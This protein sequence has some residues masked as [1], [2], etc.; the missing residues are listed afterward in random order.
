MTDKRQIKILA[1]VHGYFPNHN[2]GAEAM[3]HQILMDLKHKGHEVKV[4]T[5]D[6]GADNYE[7]IPLTEAGIG[8]DQALAEWADVIFTHLDYTRFAVRLGNRNRKPVVHL[9][10]N[11]RQL[12]YHNILDKST[13]A[14]AIANSEWIKLTIKKNI[15][16]LV[17]FPPTIPERYSVETSREAIT[18][19]NMNEAKGGKMFW[20]LARIFP[21]KKFIGVRGAYGEQ[22]EY[23][24]ELP[25]VTILKNT[26][27]IQEV[28]K[29]SGIVLMPSSYESW[30]RVAMEAAC[31][32]IPV[33]AAP[34]PGLK[35][36]LDYAGI[37]AEHDDVAGW[38]EAIRFLD[39]KK[40]Y[41]KYSKLT[42]KRSKEVAEKFAEQMER[43]EAKLIAILQ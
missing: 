32:G 1:Y 13:A 41:D 43:L 19:I 31:S 18:L 21:D 23:D 16:S 25:N 22:V 20:Q 34:T 7:G 10:H 2:A 28:Y 24:K 36:S 40:N 37:F 35:E 8:K 33:I 26:P 12:K 4:L 5:R 29:K 3:L 17:V 30:G 39:D 15:P 27:D 6:P 14:F 9:V 42:K 38:V 11:D